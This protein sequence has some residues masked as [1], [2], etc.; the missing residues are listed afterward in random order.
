VSLDFPHAGE[1]YSV[2]CAL[3]W[4][5][6]VLLLRK[7]G[8]ST[9]PV[10]LNLFKNVLAV[11]FIIITV[12]VVPH[13]GAKD[14]GPA[15]WTGAQWARLAGSGFLGLGVSDTLFLAALNRLGAGRAAIVD[16]FYSP[17]IILWASLLLPDEHATAWVFLALG[18]VISAVLVGAWEPGAGH[19]TEKRADLALGFVLGVGAMVVL[20]FA[21]VLARPVLQVSDPWW[22]TLVRLG[23]GL[24]LPS[25]MACAPSNRAA[26]LAAFTPGAHWRALLPAAFVGTY[27]SM[28]IW[29]LSFKFSVNTVIASILNQSSTVFTL[30][31]ATV[32][33][34]EPLT[35]RR[36]LAIVLGSAGALV[37]GLLGHAS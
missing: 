15:Q 32:V 5:F 17:S 30:I 9:S 4:S 20:A 11:V 14:L 24:L 31:L 13:D 10:A 19:S 34:R 33:L 18:L 3:L 1:V 2:L 36:V 16:C 26:V 35:G 37:A 6:A 29:I 8:E 12:A 23:A 7:S 28:V 21:I 22:A 27:L 25:V